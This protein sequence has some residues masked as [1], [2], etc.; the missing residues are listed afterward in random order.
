MSDETKKVTVTHLCLTIASDQEAMDDGPYADFSDKTYLL[1][2]SQPLE[3]LPEHAE[4]LRIT[5]DERLTVHLESDSRELTF[6]D[7]KLNRYL[8]AYT[9]YRFIS[10][11]GAPHKMT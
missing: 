4:M 2:L 3:L 9:T 8:R 5:A 10:Y 1:E 7:C 6:I 11:L